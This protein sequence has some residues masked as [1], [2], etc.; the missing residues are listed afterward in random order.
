[1]AGSSYQTYTSET[2]IS[3]FRAD[4]IHREAVCS[5][6]AK[7][8]PELADVAAEARQVVEVIDGRRGAVE[9]AE[10]DEIRARAVEDLEKADAID[11]YATLRGLVGVY[12]EE[13]LLAF[14]PDAPSALKRLGVKDLRGRVAAAIA[15]LRSLPDGTNR[16][17]ELVGALERELAALDAADGAEDATRAQLKS[18]RLALMVYRG[19]LAAA[20]DRQL[21]TVQKVL[22]DRTRV[23]L[24][25]LPW[26]KRAAERP[27]EEDPAAPAPVAAEPF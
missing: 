8:Y 3:A 14:L 16:Y 23:G 25:T 18:V 26:R 11:A 27:V 9:K 20:R 21:G 13:R 22:E 4:F 15:G 1:M 17:A 6:F 7:R 5:A 19:E 12:D 10:D 2:P 24:F